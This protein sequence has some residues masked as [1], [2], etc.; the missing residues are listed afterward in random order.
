[1]PLLIVKEDITR[2]RA[3]VIVNAANRNLRQGG[4]VCGA[5][6]AAAGVAEMRAACDKIGSC[7]TGGAVV[8]PAFKLPAK[9]VVHAVGPIWLGGFQGEKAQLVSCYQKALK[10]A[11][12]KNAESIAFP[13]ISSGIYGYPKEKAFRAALEVVSAFLKTR[14]MA[15]YL[16]VYDPKAAR[17]EP[18]AWAE[19]L[20]C[21]SSGGQGLIADGAAA[22]VA[23]ELPSLDDMLSGFGEIEPADEPPAPVPVEGD[24][25]GRVTDV[26][27]KKGLGETAVCA[28]SN[29]SRRAFAALRNHRKDVPDRRAALALCVGLGLNSGEARTLLATAGIALDGHRRGDVIAAWHIARGEDIHALNAT[30]Y[31]FGEEQLAFL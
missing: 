6:F 3:D 1:M 10:L 15:V 12:E 2:V 26:M 5:I 29:M 4:G 20:A 19:L 23:D 8:T 30:L 25:F 28:A 17:P 11:A 31:A 16:S 21:V 9:Y 7:P 13:L 22:P 24:F 18:A 27:R 14:E